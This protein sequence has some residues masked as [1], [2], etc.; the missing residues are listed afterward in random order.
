MMERMRAGHPMRRR[1]IHGCSTTLKNR[2]V[3]GDVTSN[4]MMT[5]VAYKFRTA[6]KL[7]IGMERRLYRLNRLKSTIISPKMH[8]IPMNLNRSSQQRFASILK[9]I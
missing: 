2:S 8:T 4:G 7:P 1:S 3:C 9:M 6:W 5:T